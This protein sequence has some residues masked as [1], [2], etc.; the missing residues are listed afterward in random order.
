M[1]RRRGF[2]PIHCDGYVFTSHPSFQ[3]VIDAQFLPDLADGFVG[4][5]IRHRRGASDDAQLFGAQLRQVGNCFF[6]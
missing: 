5:L 1:L 4:V 3:D 2:T 6:R